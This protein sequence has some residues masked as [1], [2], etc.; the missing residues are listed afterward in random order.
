M[1][2]GVSFLNKFR[3]GGNDQDQY[4]VGGIGI[5]NVLGRIIPW[6]DCQKIGRTKKKFKVQLLS[7]IK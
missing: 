5:G 6:G 1:T 2:L 7:E 3:Q 4:T